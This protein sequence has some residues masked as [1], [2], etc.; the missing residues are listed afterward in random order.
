MKLQ[1]KTWGL[2]IAA[3]FLCITV[4]IYEIKF[5]QQQS[6]IK[7]N[8]NKL[9]DFTEEDIKNI[10]VKTQQDTLEFQRNED[11]KRFWKM[12]QPKQETANNAT[13]SFLINLLVTGESERR[14]TISTSQQKNYG[15]NKP[16]AT[17]EVILNDG[18]KH[19]I[20]LGN[21]DF[22]DSFL[23]A[24]VD[25][26]NQDT[27]ELIINLVPKNYRY[28]ID[29]E[30]DEWLEINESSKRSKNTDIELKK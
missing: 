30:I 25:P 2:L 22:N 11:D 27:T 4:Y 3:V 5:Q 17:I 28:A 23:Y 6:Q 21:S 24:Q 9:F 29:R 10:T 18:N 1:K 19:Q 13:I 15:F 14:F 12:T 7:S 8:N 16:L 26:N 20:V